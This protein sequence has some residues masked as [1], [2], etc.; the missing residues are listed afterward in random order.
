MSSGNATSVSEDKIPTQDQR[1]A[2]NCNF[3]TTADG[4]V[5]VVQPSFDDSTARSK[6]P[7]ISPQK[8]TEWQSRSPDGDTKQSDT[9]ER[10]PSSPAS[11]KPKHAGHGRSLSGR[12]FESTTISDDIPTSTGE[13]QGEGEF[14]GRKHR[15][16]F[17]GD[18]TNPPSAHR[19]I[20][21]VGQSAAVARRH[22]REDSGGLDILSAAANATKEDVA[23]T[24][25]STPW[26]HA[27]QRRSYPPAQPSRSAARTQGYEGMHPGYGPPHGPPMSQ[28]PMNPP[29]HRR[30]AYAPPHG[31][32]PP[33][34]YPPPGGSYQYHHHQP[35]QSSPY[36][37][38]APRQSY[39]PP[40]A[41]YMSHYPNQA[42]E[43]YPRKPVYGGPPEPTRS[44]QLVEAEKRAF[45]RNNLAPSNEW[46]AD[47]AQSS[48]TQG[49]QTF[50]TSIAVG[51]GS[52][53][54]QP[55]LKSRQMMATHSEGVG[56]PPAEIGHHRKMS[57][58]SS[59]GTM[60]GS[61]LFPGSAAS[62]SARDTPPVDNDK[63]KGHHRVTSSSVSFLQ[64]ID[65]G[66]EM[67]ATF[68]R[69]LQASNEDGTAATSQGLPSS[70]KPEHEVLSSS[71]VSDSYSVSDSKLASGGTSKRVRRK[72]T[73]GNCA[74]RV[75]QG[76][77]CISHGAKRKTCKHQG[78][79]KN[80]KKAGLCS[81][82]GP[83]RKRC[84][85]P[86]CPKVSVQ[87]GRC[88][89][90]GA[91]KKLCAFDECTKQAI[92]GG[93]CKKHHD[94]SAAEH[95]ARD[96]SQQLCRPVQSH[97]HGHTRGLSFFQEISPDAISTLL[98]TEDKDAQ[99]S[100][101]AMW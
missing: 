34:S 25:L 1:M 26:G 80:V 46:H 72:C 74:N 98:N 10:N 23:T 39:S 4:D 57:S 21:S 67:D 94:Q 17:S 71:P 62:T 35:P 79:N 22:Q 11:R 86:G 45:E 31:A 19:R 6:S 101:R 5:L 70:F 87:G 20:N 97:H 58:F 32:Y 73:M 82:H 100:E 52:K 33:Q 99:Q 63:K 59:L 18:V 55:T 51:S 56:K 61:N 13:K 37:P 42:T 77:L 54:V 36:Y 78:C 81:T 66:L 9:E 90:H 53:T 15:R 38:G 84:E 30:V 50:V 12:F 92:L 29:P 60:I 8:S 14:A 24:G 49:S 83:A 89:S 69:N 43:D 44:D 41:H 88:I 27:P 2:R 48:N 16:I 96:R 40:R 76:G 68:L 47:G 7:T 91:K 3:E 95:P 93:M 85:H 65:V 64:G 28:H 75:V